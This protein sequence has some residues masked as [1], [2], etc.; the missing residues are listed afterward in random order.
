MNRSIKR[1]QLTV[2]QLDDRLCLSTMQ[3]SPLVP[4]EAL[5]SRTD[6]GQETALNHGVTVLAWARVDGVSPLEQRSAIRTSGDASDYSA[7]VFVGGWGSSMYQY[8]YNDPMVSSH[9]PQRTQDDVVVDGRIITG[10]NYDSSEIANSG[11]I[12]IKKLNSGG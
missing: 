5:V 6:P 11:Y 10:E 9:Q 4:P 7:I 3:G 12:R 8:A 1:N 2:E